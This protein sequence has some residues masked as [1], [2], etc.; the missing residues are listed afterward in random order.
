MEMF[1]GIDQY[2]SQELAVYQEFLECLS[3]DVSQAHAIARCN[4]DL[5][6]VDEW[7]GEEVELAQVSVTC[8]SIFSLALQRYGSAALQRILN[9]EA[10][11]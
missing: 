2:V 3:S 11:A 8:P 10:T 1:T 5:F 7:I 9:P 4:P 6:T